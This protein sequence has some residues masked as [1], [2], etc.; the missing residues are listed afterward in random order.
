[1]ASEVFFGNMVAVVVVVVWWRWC[2]ISH[3]WVHQKPSA[4]WQLIV[5]VYKEGVSSEC[6]D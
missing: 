5:L 6:Q 1:M 2:I 4:R 3:I